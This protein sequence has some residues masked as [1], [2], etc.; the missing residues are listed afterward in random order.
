MLEKTTGIVVMSAVEDRGEERT[1]DVLCYFIGRRSGLIGRT[2]LAKLAY[3]A[4]L[5]ARRYLGRPLTSLVYR[6]DYHGPFDAGIYAHLDVLRERGEIREEVLQTSEGR[7]YFRYTT[8]NP[9]RAHRFTP[10]EEA[11]LA[12]VV[13][14][15]ADTRLQDLLDDVVYETAPFLR[16]QGQPNGTVVPMELV[17]NEARDRLG[18]IDL[19]GVLRGEEEARLG[20]TVPWER[21]RRELLDR[22][23]PERG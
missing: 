11:I 12:H 14:L 21:V 3:L 2:R 7:P 5:E 16:V 15:Y 23:Q 22:D 4:D 17:D 1:R 18:G 8:G 9:L 6:L 19:D 10:A 13:G 20:K